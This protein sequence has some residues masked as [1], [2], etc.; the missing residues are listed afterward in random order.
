MKEQQNIANKHPDKVKELKDLLIKQI[1]E[2]RSTPGKTQQNDP[3]HSP[4]PQAAFA[5]LNE[6]AQH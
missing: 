1:K 3:I 5:N 4:W 6:T 2:G